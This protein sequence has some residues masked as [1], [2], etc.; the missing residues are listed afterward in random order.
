MSSRIENS[1]F[2][3]I[4]SELGIPITEVKRIVHS[5]FDAIAERARLLPYNDARRIYSKDFFCGQ[6]VYAINIPFI[7]RLGTS[8][9]RYLKWRANEAK[10][11]KQ[12]QRSKYRSRI[13]QD[14]IEHIAE[15][16]L[17]GLTPSPVF[18]KK[19]SELYNRVWLVGSNGKRLARQVI[20]KSKKNVQD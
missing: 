19:G 18:K 16:V 3:S 15:E 5:F 10:L 12:E 6:F 8:Y 17:S 4:A 2:A 11:I 14:D 9:S 13:T 1:D 20:P 7:G